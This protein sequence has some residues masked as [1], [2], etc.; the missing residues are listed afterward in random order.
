MFG[1]VD[2]PRIFPLS[3]PHPINV[4]ERE[5]VVVLLFNK[6]LVKTLIM[7]YIKI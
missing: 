3:D 6:V 2:L 5:H 4:N 7:V 1:T